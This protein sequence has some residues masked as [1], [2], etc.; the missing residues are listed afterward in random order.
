MQPAVADANRDAPNPNTASSC[1]AATTSSCPPE[2]ANFVTECFFLT[3]FAIHVG[4]MPIAAGYA[5]LM[6]ELHELQKA[7]KQLLDMSSQGTMTVSSC[8]L[9]SR[10]VMSYCTVGRVA[11][12]DVC[13]H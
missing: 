2:S 8:R 1:S 11:V 7:Y 6:K 5:S 12:F 9:I 3:M 10:L 13:A 4:F